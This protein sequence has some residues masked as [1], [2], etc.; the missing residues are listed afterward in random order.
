MPQS[1]LS[2]DFYG[3]EII[4]ALASLD[5]ET[6]TLRLRRVFE[7]P[8]RAF[9]GALVRDMQEA[10]T[11]LTHLFSQLA[12]YMPDPATVIIGLR[13]PFLSYKRSSGFKSVDSRNRIIGTREIDAAIR[14]SVPTNLSDTLEVID[15]LP[16]GYTID[17][18][19]GIINPRGM[20]G[21]TLEVETFLS[22][23]LST[24]VKTLEQ[25]FNSCGCEDPQFL[26]S[27][28]ALGEML[29]KPEEKNAA[30]LLLDIGQTHTSA[31]LYRKGVLVEA[32]ELTK[33]HQTVLEAAADLLQNDL[34]TVREVLAAYTPGSDKIMDDLLEDAEIQFLKILRKE[35]LQSS[36]TYLKHPSVNLVLCGTMTDK[37][38]QKLIKKVFNA[39]KVRAGAVAAFMTDCAENTPCAAGALCLLSHFLERTQQ[40]QPLVPARQPG[41]LGGFLD[42]IG[43]GQLFD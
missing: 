34:Q 14:N 25:L 16:Q 21:F 33:G 17:G 15:I 39:G 35:L 43:L 18:N 3:N 30:T 8:C 42:K 37:P 24:H 32:W 9:S 10:H 11:E 7:Q 23:A 38:F 13:G 2:L 36:L 22:C 4:A 31:T 20:A 27:A 40:Q 5:E 1:I 29:L 12:P 26:P 19:I 28:I 41:I 6:D